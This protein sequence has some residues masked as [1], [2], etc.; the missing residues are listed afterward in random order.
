MTTQISENQVETAASPM[1]TPDNFP[2]TWE[3]PA[4]A[5]LFWLQQRMHFPEPMLPLDEWFLRTEFE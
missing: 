2:V 4:D 1:P 3:D 5:D